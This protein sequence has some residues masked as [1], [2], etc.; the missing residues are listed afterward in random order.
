[1]KQAALN[2]WRECN[3]VDSTLN[4]IWPKSSD[5]EKETKRKLLYAWKAQIKQ[6]E[7]A[8]KPGLHVS[9]IRPS[10]IACV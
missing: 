2:Y 8:I 1:L 7:N 4:K 3:Y 6:K 10:G 5:E 9:K